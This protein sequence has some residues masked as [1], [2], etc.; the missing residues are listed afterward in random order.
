M[1]ERAVQVFIGQ[2]IDFDIDQVV[3]F[4]SP[5]GKF[6]LMGQIKDLVLDAVNDE[7]AEIHRIDGKL[8]YTI[9]LDDLYKTKGD[10][11]EKVGT[12]KVVGMEVDKHD[13]IDIKDRS[14]VVRFDTSRVLDRMNA[15]H[16]YTDPDADVT[17]L[18]EGIDKMT[19]LIK[20]LDG[21]NQALM[22]FMTNTKIKSEDD[23]N[24]AMFTCRMNDA[25][26][27]KI[28]ICDIPYLQGLHDGHVMY[29][30]HNN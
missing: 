7:C 9:P 12:T 24:T 8:T 14:E 3:Y 15:L 17:P 2:T 18:A 4:K 13:L 22:S 20:I 16:L 30:I 1:S 26:I 11:I 25:L 21:Y 19:K 27:N 23:E 10:A 5:N 6:I 29:A 28:S